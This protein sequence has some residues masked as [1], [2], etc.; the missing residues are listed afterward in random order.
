MKNVP[1][2]ENLKVYPDFLLLWKCVIICPNGKRFRTDGKKEI[3]KETC[4]GGLKDHRCMNLVQGYFV[5]NVCICVHA[6]TI[7][8]KYQINKKE[9]ER[10]VC[11]EK[12]VLLCTDSEDGSFPC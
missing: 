11:G 12:V 8:S 1:F 6:G 9:N 7:L 4:G 2:S 5:T 10:A 3:L